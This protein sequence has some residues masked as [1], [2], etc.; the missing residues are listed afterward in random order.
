ML[1]QDLL[2]SAKTL[3]EDLK[4]LR[5]GANALNVS[6]VSAMEQDDKV[7]AVRA[8]FPDIIEA[9]DKSATVISKAFLSVD[10]EAEGNSPQ[11][12]YDILSGVQTDVPEELK[13]AV[14]DH[15]SNVQGGTESQ[16]VELFGKD[17][18][19]SCIIELGLIEELS[20]LINTQDEVQSL[21]A[22]LQEIQ[23]VPLVTQE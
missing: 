10:W 4:E 5:D 14:E 21:L 9:S 7:N 17:P 19:I 6:F 2:F 20:A 13:E 8:L 3:L 1:N 23:N 15:I 18:M 11:L 22:A 16:M 12:L